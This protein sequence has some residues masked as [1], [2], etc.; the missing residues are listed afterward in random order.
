VQQK[1]HLE[2]GRV[3]QLLFQ[4]MQ[5]ATAH[6][7]VNLAARVSQRVENHLVERLPAAR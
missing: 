5:N 1:K 3:N 6:Q 7:N 2:C 4:S